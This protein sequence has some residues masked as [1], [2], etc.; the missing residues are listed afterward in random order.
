MAY[1]NK[2]EILIPNISLVSADFRN[3]DAITGILRDIRPEVIIHC[4][5]ETNVDYCEENKLH[6]YRLN[7]AATKYLAMY[8]K[9]TSCKLIY[10]STDSIYCG[11]KG[12]YH[13]YEKPEPRNVYAK[14][15]LTGEL[16]VQENAYDYLILLNQHLWLER[17]S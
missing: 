16:S 10:I 17:P 9:M 3:K 2:N 1:L 15:K 12:N 7:A 4:A 11:E 14:T 8:S 13:E 6:A 5:A